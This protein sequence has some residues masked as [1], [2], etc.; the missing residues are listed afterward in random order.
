MT[1]E[2]VLASKTREGVCRAVSEEA[3]ACP[4]TG[5]HP[6]TAGLPPAPSLGFRRKLVPAVAR[7][8]IGQGEERWAQNTYILRMVEEKESLD[9]VTLLGAADALSQAYLFLRLL[10]YG[11]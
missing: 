7:A 5:T 1:T 3:F 2:P 6:G 10:R 8:I 9:L 11:R 4:M